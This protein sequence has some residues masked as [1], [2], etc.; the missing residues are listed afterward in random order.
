M[1]EIK[2]R[3]KRIDNNEF[4]YGHYY[5][6]D[7]RHFI[8]FENH[9]DNA[10]S[11]FNIEIKVETLG[12]FTGLFDKNGKEIYEKDTV[13]AW[14]EGYNH[15]GEVRWILEGMPRI[16]IYPAFANQGFWKLHGSL[17]HNG[18]NVP[19]GQYCDDGVEVIELLKEE[20]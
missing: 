6:R 17:N 18:K 3:G 20:K 2:F 8:C 16:I 10:D 5:E 4:V 7:F 14:S 19:R 9:S 12:Q 1:R 11:Y 15:T 13:S